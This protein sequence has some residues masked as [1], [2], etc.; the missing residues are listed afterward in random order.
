MARPR[1]FTIGI[2][3]VGVAAIGVTCYLATLMPA[4]GSFDWMGFGILAAGVGPWLLV[5]L[6]LLLFPIRTDKPASKAES[7]TT[8]PHDP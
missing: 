7:S 6:G 8:E 3:M 1:Q 5:G 4:W 2:G